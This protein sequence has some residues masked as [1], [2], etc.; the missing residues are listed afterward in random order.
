MRDEF[1][2]DEI[3]GKVY[4]SRLMKR[5]LVY[6]KP[7]KKEVAVSFVL[8]LLSAGVRLLSPYLTKIAIDQYIVIGDLNGLLKIAIYL[9]GVIVAEFWISYFE[10]Y[11][12]LMVGQRIMYDMRV[13]I[14]SHLQKL[15]VGFFDKNPVGRLMTRVMGDVEALNE[16]FASGI[17]GIFGD[18][19]S[20]LGIMVAMFALNWKLA[21]VTFTVL[22]FVFMATLYFQLTSR[23]AYREARKQ[24]ARLN[25]YMQECLVGMSTIQL[26]V[27]EKRSFRRYDEI[28]RSY[29]KANLR[30]IQAMALFQPLIEVTGSLATAMIIWYGGGQIL[31]DVLTLGTLVAFIQY[32][33]RFFFPIRDLTEKYNVLQA[34][35]ASSERIFQLLDTPPLISEKPDSVQI[36]QLEGNIEFRNVWLAYNPDEYVLKGISFKVDKGEKVAIV[37]ATGAGKTSIINLLCRFYDIQKGE[38][39]IDGVD[40]RDIKLE[41]LRRSIGVVQQ[42]TFLFSGTIAG[43]IRLGHSEISDEALV[44]AA[45]DVHA[46]EFIAQLTGEYKAEV[47]ERGA[48][49][50]V[51]QKQLIAFARALAYNP[52]I[53][54]LDEATSS[55]DTETELLIQDALKRLMLGRTSIVI[56][57]RLSTI[58]NADKIM[59]MHKGEIREIGDHNSLLKQR[60]IYYRLYQLQYKAQEKVGA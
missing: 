28:N 18:L 9:V 30:S 21:L 37:G 54:I 39:L 16:L 1:F 45:K 38:I 3:L 36:D 2:E 17:V 14:F 13:Q 27:Q 29:L 15:H 41:Q 32:G 52:Q 50:S 23:R 42:D 11:I 56:A 7:Y 26:F 48:T 20:L 25:A 31:K 10:E 60:G 24:L 43:N 5:L 49:L 33:Q 46:H 53:L 55:I 34:A 57:H 47:K 51:G 35:M 44:H 59:V 22:P 8:I 40:I 12:M 4:D 19:F 6:L 58:Q